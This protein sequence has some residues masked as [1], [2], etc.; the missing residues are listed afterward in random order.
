MIVTPLPSF[1]HVPDPLDG[2]SD[3]LPRPPLERVNARPPDRAEMKQRRRAASWLSVGWLAS[4]LLV[5]G[6]RHDL[7]SLPPVYAASQIAAPLL[8]ALGSLYVALRPGRWGL[9]SSTAG[10]AALA[11]GGPAAF[12]LLGFASRPPLLGAGEDTEPLLAALVCSDLMLVWMS[13]PLFAAAFALRRAFAAAAVWRSALTGSGV[14]LA[15]AVM[16]NLHCDNGDPVHL[17]I[18]HAA[19]VAAGSLFAALV[20]TRWLRA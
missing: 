3:V 16:I 13:A 8:L 17:L 1:D 4:H 19:P 18:G 9:G 14:G 15:S 6:V 11:I 12:G 10:I 7:W 2:A 20:V 5:F